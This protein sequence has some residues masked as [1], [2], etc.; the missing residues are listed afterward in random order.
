[1]NVEIKGTGAE[2]SALTNWRLERYRVAAA[3][4]RTEAECSGVRK[5]AVNLLQGGVIDIGE[6]AALFGGQ[7][8]HL[9]TRSLDGRFQYAAGDG[10]ADALARRYSRAKHG[11]TSDIEVLV[12]AMVASFLIR[13]DD[14]VTSLHAAFEQAKARGDYVVLFGTGLRNVPAASNVMCEMFVEE[15]NVALVERAYPTIANVRLPR[16]AP[17]VDN[18]AQLSLE[19]RVQVSQVQDH[20]LPDA[21]FY[22]GNGVHVLFADDVIVTGA[23]AD[24][25]YASAMAHG[26]RSFHAIYPVLVDP[27][28]ALR[29][30][31]L[32]ESLNTCSVGAGIDDGLLD[33]LADSDH[34]PVLRT[35][36][37]AFSQQHHQGFPGLMRRLGPD[38][39]RRL[40][41]AALSA[42]FIRHVKYAQSLAAARDFLDA[43]P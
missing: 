29:E 14:P 12:Q 28:V 27:V 11:S 26:A 13:L 25:V 9:L 23:T 41:R 35:L 1:M 3:A 20:V 40:Y 19:D 7:A 24:K 15:V 6:Y 5:E 34:V 36:R 30:P 2:A 10:N 8:C 22:R 17:P 38:R 18:Y 42:D 37:L 33:I 16:I 21:N 4:A 39:V 32:E 43:R 31:E